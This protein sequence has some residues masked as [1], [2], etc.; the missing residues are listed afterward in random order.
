MYALAEY[1]D[2]AYVIDLLHYGPVYDED[3]HKRFY[4]NGHMNASGYLF[5]ARLIDSYIDYL[6]RH[7]PA[8]F[9]EVALIGTEIK[10]HKGEKK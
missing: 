3:F 8:D 4:L 2:N 6:I 5:T 7:N 10:N 9:A 1:F